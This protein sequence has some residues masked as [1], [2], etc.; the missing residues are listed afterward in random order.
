MRYLILVLGLA[1]WSGQVQAVELTVATNKQVL[2]EVLTR[3]HKAADP[4]WTGTHGAAA[5]DSLCA[6]YG[7]H[8][9][10]RDANGAPRAAT[11]NE[12]AAHVW[13]QW[14][15]A[16]YAPYSIRKKSNASPVVAD[17]LP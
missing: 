10:L 14:W 9:G 11:L 4:T 8:A 3:L 6:A 2:A 5:V 7:A 17:S 13:G 16:L 1:A 15:G 12:F